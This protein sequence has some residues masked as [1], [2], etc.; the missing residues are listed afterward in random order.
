VTIPA[1]DASTITEGGRPIQEAAP[2]VRVVS[3]KN[4]EAVLEVGSGHYKFQART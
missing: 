2:N 4:G 1:K 3:V